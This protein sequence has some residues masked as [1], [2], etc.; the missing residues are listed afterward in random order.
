MLALSRRRPLVL[1]IEDLHWCDATTLDALDRL[2]ARV[3]GA[4][5]LV[6][7]T[8]R[9]EFEAAW[10]TPEAVTTLALGPLGDDVVRELAAALGGGLALPE[11]VVDRI[12][13]SAGGNPLYVEEVGRAVLESGLLVRGEERWDLASPLTDLE[14]PGTLHASLLAR[15]DALGPAKSVAQ[16]AAVLGRT[17]PFDLLVT[18]SGMDPT[19]LPGSSNGW[20][21]VD[22]C[23]TIRAIRTGTPS[24]T[25]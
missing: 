8:A 6:L 20:W 16:L 2:L 24:S 18:V 10:V 17:F 19:C 22:S 12:V 14:I 3:A 9:P 4:P 5:V 11:Q 13:A 1:C 25:S 15:L 7:L 21:R 23:S